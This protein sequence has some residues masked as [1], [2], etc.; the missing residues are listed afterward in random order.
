MSSYN[1]GSGESIDENDSRIY[2]IAVALS[3]RD[4][5]I[6]GLRTLRGTT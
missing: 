2:V 3:N 1:L 4:F 5:V 6:S